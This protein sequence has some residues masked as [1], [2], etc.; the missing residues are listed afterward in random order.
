MELMRQSP[1]FQHVF[2]FLVSIGVAIT[3]TPAF[4]LVNI[5]VL[6]THP[7]LS[8][9]PLTLLRFRLLH[10]CINDYNCTLALDW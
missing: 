7:R 4:S 6:A 2:G 3:V 8:K 9:T 1:G 10:H 5:T